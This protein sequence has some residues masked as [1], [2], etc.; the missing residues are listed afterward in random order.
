MDLHKSFTLEQFK[1]FLEFGFSVLSSYGDYLE[2]LVLF[3]TIGHCPSRK[4]WEGWPGKDL[5]R[6]CRQYLNGTL[7][8]REVWKLV[9]QKCARINVWGGSKQWYFLYVL[10]LYSFLN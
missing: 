8:R 1:K 4:D 10:S 7:T 9:K 5:G 3:L 2:A 6:L